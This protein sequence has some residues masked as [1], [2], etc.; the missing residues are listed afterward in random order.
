VSVQIKW[1]FAKNEG[2]RE[3]GFH[4]AGV[5][6]FTGNFDRYLA[7]EMI[8]NSLDARHDLKKPARVEFKR[9]TIKRSDIP[10]ME[11]LKSALSSC[12]E[13]W[14]A[15]KK[16][17]GFFQRAAELASAKEVHALEVSDFNTTGVQGSDTERDKNWYSLVRCAG[18]SPKSGGA[19]GSFGIGKNAPFAASRMRTVLYSTE[20]IDGHYAFQG[21]AILASHNNGRGEI[22]QPVGFLGGAK[23]ASLRAKEDIPEQFRRNKAGTEIIIL[24]FPF[25][26]TWKQDLIYSVL[27]NFWPAISFGDLEVRVD[28]TLIT[29]KNLDK[30][31][32][33]QFPGNEDF[34]A[35]L[36]YQALTSPTIPRIEKKLPTLG[37][38]EMYLLATD[39]E[40]M[41]KTVAMVRKNGMQ[42]F[43]R[44]F[45]SIVPFCGVFLC[46]DD[47]GNQVLRDMEPPGHDKWD[48]DLPEKGANKKA[49][50]ELSAFIR[51]C[52]KQLS[53]TDDREAIPV[54]GLNKYLPD[55][56]ETPEEAFDEGGAEK[57]KKESFKRQIT[58][59]KI[60]SRKVEP[61]KQMRP[62]AAAAG[63]EEGVPSR[64][65]NGG[66]GGGGGGGAGDGEGAG[67][68]SRP[69]IPIEYRTFLLDAAANTYRVKVKVVREATP[70][71]TRLNMLLW[72]VGD[73]GKVSA[74]ITAARR[75][76]GTDISVRQDGVGPVEVP[77][78]GFLTFDVVLG[79]PQR[80]AIEVA[81]YEA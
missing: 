66:K 59:G 68:A 26:E 11:G 38:C 58:P 52:I 28:D 63:T 30:L 22:V 74:G 50:N 21:V 61:R 64:G 80:I 57:Q 3:T 25:A 56:D 13:Y 45:R 35:R 5:E 67:A 37:T 78:E 43:D 70:K 4:D 71:P 46:R 53:L 77:E 36:Y 19:G 40:N 69:A 32:V 33:E 65:G 34:V 8:Q 44:R 9:R 42:I 55:D 31:L 49:H 6:T 20:T 27:D 62:D 12:A 17:Y 24:G 14:K 76:D 15:D 7:R 29:E 47:E 2:G 75:L 23:G 10:D 39:A 81:A 79:E 72:A 54:P 16:A 48:P 73:D 18:S 51:S 60:E 1:S 41:P